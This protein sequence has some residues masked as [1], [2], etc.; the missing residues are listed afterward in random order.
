MEELQHKS[1]SHLANYAVIFFVL[2]FNLQLYGTYFNQ[3]LLLSA[4]YHNMV[5]P[6]NLSLV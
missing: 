2:L 1:L 5:H 3:Q 4:I 6:T